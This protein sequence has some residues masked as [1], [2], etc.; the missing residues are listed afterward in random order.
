MGIHQQLNDHLAIQ[1]LADEIID[2]KGDK[3][4]VREDFIEAVYYY[5]ILW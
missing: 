4:L 3:L 1:R 5:F 2:A